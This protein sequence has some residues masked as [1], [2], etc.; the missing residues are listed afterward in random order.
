ML[1]GKQSP[2]EAVEKMAADINTSIE[3]YNL[4]NS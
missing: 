1:N 4:L 3:D 2:E